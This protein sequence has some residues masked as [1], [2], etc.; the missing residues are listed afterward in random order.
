MIMMMVMMM[1]MMMTGV[2]GR[3]KTEASRTGSGAE[4]GA[5]FNFNL[6]I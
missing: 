1:M 2:W 6:M 3:S 4:P 5:R